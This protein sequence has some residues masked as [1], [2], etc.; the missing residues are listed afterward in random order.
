MKRKGNILGDLV[1]QNKQSEEFAVERESYVAYVERVHRGKYIAAKF[2]R[3]ICERLEAVE[4]GEITRLMLFI[5]PR[6]GKSQTVTETFPSWYLGKH[7][8][9]RVIEVSYGKSFAEKFGRLN[10][11]KV[12][13][14]GEKVFGVKVS[15]DNASKTNWSIEGDTGGMIS[16]GLGGSITGEGADVLIIDD[17][18]K[19][20]QEAESPTMRRRIWDEWQ[21][22]LLTRLHA[23]ATII[24]IM[25][26]WRDDDLAGMI[27]KQAEEEGQHWEIVSLPTIAEEGD[28]L[29]RRRG[30]ALWPEHGFDEKWAA[31]KKIEVGTRTWQALY[32]QNPAPSEGNIL[33][34]KWWRY[35]HVMPAQFDEIIQSWD[36]TFKDKKENDYVVG[37][38]WGRI[39]ADKYLLDQ[40][41][42][43]LDFPKTLKAMRQMYKKWP[44]ARVKLVEDKA[45]GSGIISM[46]KHE[47]PGIIAVNPEGSK[48]A[49]VWAVSAD[50]EAGNVY[51]PAGAAFKE[52]F[53][54]ECSRFPLGKHDDQVDS[55]SQALARFLKKNRRRGAIGVPGVVTGKIE[56]ADV[57]W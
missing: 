46:L 51:L 26:R 41:R 5:G 44:Q 23:D 42:E 56:S 38:I 40:L 28:I 31:K 52:C 36:M 39:G 50:I 57:N 13:E 10:R 18:I 12:E 22:T 32:Q 49:R 3:Y 21:D 14:Y 54:E 55:M 11:K 29:G 45:N 15:S 2:H 33:Q 4:R 30:E 35:Y 9:K 7:P 17:L 48:E 8:D 53:V 43:Q 34:K 47:I 24:L 6:H 1:E 20:R 16:V 19:N 25:T 27:L 37:Q